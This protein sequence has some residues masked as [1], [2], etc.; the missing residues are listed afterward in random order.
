[1]KSTSESQ[2]ASSDAPESVRGLLRHSWI[3]SLAPLFQRLLAIVLIRLY[4]QRLSL[5][6]FGVLEIV[7]LLILIVPQLVGINLLS[8]LTRFYFEHQDPR[9]R[10]QVV[11]SA[12]IALAVASF[13]VAG[14]ALAARA[15]LVELLFSLPAGESPPEGLLD[16]LGLAIL[17]VPFSICT[18]SGLR[19]LQILKLSRAST[20]VQLVKTLVEAALKLWMLFGL[21]WGV[22][23][24]LLSVLIGEVLT[25]LGFALWMARTLRTGFEWSVFRPLFAFSLPLLPLGLAQLGLHQFGRQVLEHFGPQQLVDGPGAK[26][27]VTLA[28]EWVGVFG[29]GYKIAFLIHTAVLSSFMQIWQPHVFSLAGEQR[30]RELVRLGNWAFAAL[31]AIYIPAALFSRQ[32]VDLLAGSP[33]FREAWRV[34]PIIVVA[35]LCYGSYALSQV[36]LLAEKRN[37]SLLALN[38]AALALGVALSVTLVP[39]WSEHGYTAAALA[40]LGCFAPLALGA[41]MLARAAKSPS[42]SFGRA[43]A[44]VAT[45]AATTGA[46]LAVDA[47]RDPLEA[48]AFAPVL[49]AKLALALLAYGALWRLGLDADGRAGLARLAREALARVGL[50]TGSR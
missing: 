49:G 35:Y 50:R 17:I 43:F 6:E 27:G 41:E 5:G 13:A 14:L 26:L 45:V 42:R 31:C 3:Y 30:A 9:R 4:T 47:W 33:E 12:T 22:S 40:T 48:G 44:L 37:W 24:F 18:A 32:A 23:G 1:L 16:A 7:D 10:A 21:E 39:R 19:Y 46:A 2:G 34:T 15:P 20:T 38:V 29:L 36:A 28:R 11:S 8:G 25:S